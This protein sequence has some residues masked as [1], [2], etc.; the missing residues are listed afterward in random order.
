ME[1]WILFILLILAVIITA[2]L[3]YTVNNNAGY[4]SGR[5]EDIPQSLTIAEEAERKFLSHKYVP[6]LL[7]DA[8]TIYEYADIKYRLQY[9]S[10]KRVPHNKH[11]GQLKLF[12][13]ELQFLTHYAKGTTLLIYAGAAPSNK[14]PMLAELFPKT[15]F[16]LVDPNEIYAMWR[17]GD[18]YSSSQHIDEMLYF[19]VAQSAKN[20]P[21]YKMRVQ[22]NSNPVVNVHG[23]GHVQR[24]EAKKARPEV[25][26]AEVAKLKHRFYVIEDFYT[27]EISKLFSNIKKY[28]TIDT[29]LF[30]SDIRTTDVY[31]APSNLD[32]LYNSAQQYNWIEA[33][34]PDMY[35][36]KFRCPYDWEPRAKIESAYKKFTYMH[37]D[38]SACKLPILDDHYNKKFV[39][40][41]P[42]HIW[43]QAF[44]RPHSTE[45]RLVGCGLETHEYD[46]RE[47]EEKHFYFNALHRPYG[48][49]T[50][51]EKYLNRSLGIDRCG[52]CALMCRI[53]EEYVEKYGG[54]VLDIIK[55]VL[56]STRRN[57][58][59]TT[60]HGMY[61]HKLYSPP[62][63]GVAHFLT[64]S[65]L[66]RTSYPKLK[67]PVISEQ[68]AINFYAA[69]PEA[70]A[71]AVQHW[72]IA[73]AA[74]GGVQ[75]IEAALGVRF[76]DLFKSKSY[77]INSFESSYEL[78]INGASIQLPN[79]APLIDT[80]VTYFEVP[81]ITD[82]TFYG[83][84][85]A[86]GITSGLVY[87][88]AAEPF[89]NL[90]CS[91]F[92]DGNWQ[93][94]TGPLVVYL[95]SQAI[96]VHWYVYEYFA[97]RNVPVVYLMT[98]QGEYFKDENE[99]QCEEGPVKFYI[100]CAN[101]EFTLN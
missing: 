9:G 73:H 94:I 12:L 1:K 39:Y 57:V 90:K 98:K 54:N 33:L 74:D 83:A 72:V 89:A 52:D 97:R 59:G 28:G 60:S 81:K 37:E 45:A 91:Y 17:D 65:V 36:L 40:L 66:P 62:T 88:R 3:L 77:T 51:H 13:T 5:G 75:K 26:A 4:V 76:A 50:T 15:H 42:Q 7:D 29:V 8:P 16:V 101:I 68:S 34:N 27:T 92:I 99:L 25:I 41:K 23:M 46:I 32:V 18:Q 49:H 20:S 70:D 6:Q 79:T 85:S 56:I 64:Y 43:I 24:N 71:A 58:F 19:T 38:L 31:E 84:L 87:S 47:Y 63:N 93:D 44:S 48:W 21:G 2:I 11:N 30:V 61:Y 95:G 67:W 22:M 82:T 86:A 80:C 78:T 100:L 96:D 14:M 35:M 10:D 69:M 55:D 53:V